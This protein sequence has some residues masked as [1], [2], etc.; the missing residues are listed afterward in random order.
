[1]RKYL[2]FQSRP[3]SEHK[4]LYLH[5]RYSWDDRE[6]ICPFKVCIMNEDIE[7]VKFLWFKLKNPKGIFIGTLHLAAKKGCFD[8]IQSILDEHPFYRREA[9]HLAAKF[10]NVKMAQTIVHQIKICNMP[11]PRFRER[12]VGYDTYDW[13]GQSPSYLAAKYGHRKVEEVLSTIVYS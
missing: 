3:I 11:L 12:K 13:C 5:A 9:L 10:G 1:M 6:N 2:T 7:A 8:F 4:T